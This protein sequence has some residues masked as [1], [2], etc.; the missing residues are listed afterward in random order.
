MTISG[1]KTEQI[2]ALWWGHFSNNN[3]F[4]TT[5]SFFNIYHTVRTIILAFDLIFQTLNLPS[6]N[7]ILLRL[8][9]ETLPL[10]ATYYIFIYG[11]KCHLCNRHGD[12]QCVPSDSIVSCNLFLPIYIIELDWFI[13]RYGFH[14]LQICFRLRFIYVQHCY[15]EIVWLVSVVLGN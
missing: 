6:G 14:S 10:S 15:T 7:A 9:Y 13:P 2:N 12:K 11:Q 4:Y 5:L 1:T 3:V 8:L